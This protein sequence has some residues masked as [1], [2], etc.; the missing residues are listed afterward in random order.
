MEARRED[1]YIWPLFK[2]KAI[3]HSYHREEKEM[4]CLFA[5]SNIILFSE[6]SVLGS[7]FSFGKENSQPV[8]CSGNSLFPELF[9]FMLS[10]G[11]MTKCMDGDFFSKTDIYNIT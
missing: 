10:V 5:N 3:K 1:V 4:F 8:C 6:I 9:P 11:E 2:F 7:Q